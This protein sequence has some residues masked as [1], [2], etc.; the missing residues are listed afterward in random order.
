MASVQVNRQRLEETMYV[1]F[2][3][4]L[5]L[6]GLEKQRGRGF[7]LIMQRE[8]EKPQKEELLWGAI[9]VVQRELNAE[10][11]YLELPTYLSLLGCKNVYGL[12]KIA[13]Y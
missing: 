1:V 4:L 12:Q 13:S 7:I 6:W 10:L 9:K 8:G 2:S 3:Q 11:L 5:Y